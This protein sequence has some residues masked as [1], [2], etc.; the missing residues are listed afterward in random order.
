[1][2]FSGFPVDQSIIEGIKLFLSHR[3]VDVVSIALVVAALIICDVHVDGLFGNDWCSRIKEIER[4]F[5]QQILD[6]PSQR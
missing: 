2:D 3:T 6:G 5:L 1:M 4:I